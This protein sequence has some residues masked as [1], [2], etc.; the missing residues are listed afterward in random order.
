MTELLEVAIAELH[1]LPAAEQDV[2]AQIILD[3]IAD[4]RQWDQQFEQSRD[5][6]ARL[7]EKV[8]ADIRDGKTK[9]IGIDEL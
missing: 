3:E 9:P 8:R 1:K 4:E 7:A 6:L 5:A 2:V